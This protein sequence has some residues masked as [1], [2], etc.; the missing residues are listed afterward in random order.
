[1]LGNVERAVVVDADFGN[2]VTRL[3]RAN[4]AV[5]LDLNYR[6]NE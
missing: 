4:G 1:L 3:A 2:D 5:F 6:H